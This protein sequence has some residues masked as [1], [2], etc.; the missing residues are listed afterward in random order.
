MGLKPADCARLSGQ[1]AALE[2]LLLF[3]TSMAMAREAAEAATA[4][5]AANT[6]T[7]NTRTS[8]K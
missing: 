2:H 6:E 5:E 8:F 3:E 4:R 7:A 1:T